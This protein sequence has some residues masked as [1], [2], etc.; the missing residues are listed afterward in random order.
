MKT[1]VLGSGITALAYL[2]YDREAFALAGDQVGGLFKQQVMGPQYVW[3]T[4]STRKLL[5]ELGLERRVRHLSIGYSLGGNIYQASDITADRMDEIR[6]QYAMKTRGIT[7]AAS[8]MSSGNGAPEIFSISVGQLV[9]TLLDR[10]RLRLIPCSATGVYMYGRQV[11]VKDEAF[12]YDRLVS[13]IPAPIFLGLTRNGDQA[14]LL[15]A[16][17]KAYEKHEVGGV[18][19]YDYVYYPEEEPWHR[20]SVMG[21][22]GEVTSVI[23]EYTL[24]PGQDAPEGSRRHRAG[25][26]VG[27]REV[28][29]SLPSSVE[30]LGRY[31]EWRHDRRLENVLDLLA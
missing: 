27:G 17:D 13:T 16:R 23:R 11:Y 30:L 6:K 31:A 15:L 14:K 8:H 2:Y 28:L 29:L 24:L 22:V 7:P 20:I 12:E 9:D 10:V 5:N 25:Q 1:L 4:P 26:I 19:G 3:A 21:G 18:L